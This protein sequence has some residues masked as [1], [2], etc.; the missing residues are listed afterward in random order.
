M[1]FICTNEVWNA[2]FSSP[3]RYIHWRGKLYIVSSFVRYHLRTLDDNVVQF[4]HV[5]CS[6]IISFHVASSVSPLEHIRVGVLNVSS[7]VPP[8]AI[9]H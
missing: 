8:P 9:C 3:L 1:D 6:R 4:V 2:I 5:Y 7:Y